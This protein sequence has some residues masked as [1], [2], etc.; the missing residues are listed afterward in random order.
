MYCRGCGTALQEEALYWAPADDTADLRR[1][2]ES[3]LDTCHEPIAQVE[4]DRVPDLLPTQA[5]AQQRYRHALEMR[6][7]G[8][9]LFERAQTWPLLM[10]ASLTHTLDALGIARDD[11]SHSLSAERGDA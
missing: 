10:L 7:E 11:L 9:E 4:A 6:A 1:V 3:K 2:I 5:P 8:M